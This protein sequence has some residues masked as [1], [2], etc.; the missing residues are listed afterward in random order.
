MGNYNI[1]LDE[2]PDEALKCDT[3]PSIV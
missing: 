2:L 1:N 3:N